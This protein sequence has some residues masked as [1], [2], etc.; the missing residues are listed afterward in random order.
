LGLLHGGEYWRLR[1][2]GEFYEGAAIEILRCS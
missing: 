1:Q 2:D